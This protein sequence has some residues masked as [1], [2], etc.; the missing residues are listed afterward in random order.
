[1]SDSRWHWAGPY[2]QSS[3]LSCTLCQDKPF[4]LIRLVSLLCQAHWM[5]DFFHQ[6]FA[7]T[8]PPT[9]TP[10]SAFPVYVSRSIS[11]SPYLRSFLWLLQPRRLSTIS[12][13]SWGL[14]SISYRLR[15]R[16]PFSSHDTLPWLNSQTSLSENKSKFES[17]MEVSST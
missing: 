10:Q 11:D 4:P 13:S 6:D 5:F 15:L 7:L 14:L 3:L 9:S 2:I 16:C 17:Q 8:T 1:M 12:P